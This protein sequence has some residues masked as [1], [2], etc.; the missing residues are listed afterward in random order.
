[1]AET[2]PTPK[3]EAAEEKVEK[4]VGKWI[5]RTHVSA[6]EVEEIAQGDMEPVTNSSK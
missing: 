6:Q 5:D 3:R 1:V 2:Q 4:M